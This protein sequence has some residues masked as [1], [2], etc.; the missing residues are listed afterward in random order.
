M[1]FD[2]RAALAR[3][4]GKT[5]E[6]RD[7]YRR[8][9]VICADNYGELP[10]VFHVED[11]WH[12]AFR[13]KWFTHTK[14]GVHVDLTTS[15]HTEYSGISGEHVWSAGKTPLEAIEALCEARW[16]GSVEGVLTELP[17][18]D[19]RFDWGY[20]FVSDGTSFKCAGKFVAGGVILTWWK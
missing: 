3:L 8:L 5:F 12:K 6:V 4:Q 14:D 16:N 7:L 1:K 18:K 2:Y 9:G 11:Y 17:C 20:A 19:N 10:I 13:N 15:P